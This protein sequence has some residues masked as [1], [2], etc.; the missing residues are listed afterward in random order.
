MET[1]PAQGQGEAAQGGAGPAVSA[2]APRASSRGRRWLKRIGFS[3]LAL[4]VVWTLFSVVYNAV[5]AG[6]ASPPAGLTYVQTG[7]ALTRYRVW[8]NPSAPGPAIVLIHGAFESADTWEPLARILAQTHHVE[9]YDVKGYGYTQRTGSYST[10]ALADQLNAFLTA[11]GLVKPILVGHSSGAGVIA[12]FVLDHPDRAGGIVFLDGDGLSS[13]V[14]TWAP[15]LLLDPWR[16]TL[17]RL[18]L[19]SDAVIRALYNATCDAACPPL[20]R[21]G[22]DQWRRPFEVAGAEQALWSM[23]AAGIPGLPASQVARIAALRIP[24]AVI[25]GANDS[26][27]TRNSPAQTAQRIGAPAPTIIPG[28][29]HLSFVG[30]PTEVAAAIEQLY[31]RARASTP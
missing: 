17:F 28:A 10:R 4:F 30:H 6:R 7:D 25:F 13:G 16:T 27:F 1:Q 5:T 20:D 31:Q 19:H 9:A 18:V 12:R 3:L 11:R 29:A 21:A 2:G 26:E 14:S 24:A 23:L 22:V 8:G 15:R